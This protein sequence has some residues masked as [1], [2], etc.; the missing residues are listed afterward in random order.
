V[1]E[2]VKDVDPTNPD[3]D[4]VNVAV[5][6]NQ[7]DRYTAHWD[8]NDNDIIDGIQEFSSIDHIL[9]SYWLNDKVDSVAIPHTYNP[10]DVSDHFPIIVYFTLN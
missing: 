8:R 2:V 3:D 9:V 1:L 7:P 4:L 5:H 10:I 6:L